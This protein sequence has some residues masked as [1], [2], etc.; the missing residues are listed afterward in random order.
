MSYL[1]ENNFI[2]VY[3]ADIGSIVKIMDDKSDFNNKLMYESGGTFNGYCYKDYN[4]RHLA[5][6]N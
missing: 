5:K 6:L 2:T 3:D 4:N 1:Y